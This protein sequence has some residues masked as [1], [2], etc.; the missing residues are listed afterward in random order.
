MLCF[1]KKPK[2][3]AKNMKIEDVFFRE[4]R[5]NKLV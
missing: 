1:L 3:E 2:K 4:M 5:Y